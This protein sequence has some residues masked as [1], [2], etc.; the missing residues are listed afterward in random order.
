MFDVRKPVRFGLDDDPVLDNRDGNSGNVLPFHLRPDVVIDVI[1][2]GGHGGDDNHTDRK[3]EMT[4]SFH[5]TSTHVQWV[6]R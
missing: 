4:C 2:V 6:T 3:D 1:R 5:D